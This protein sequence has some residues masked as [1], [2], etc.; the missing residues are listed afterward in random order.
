MRVEAAERRAEIVPT[1][2]PTPLIER[3]RPQQ[4]GAALP[5]EFHAPAVPP[6]S[7]APP[8]APIVKPTDSPEIVRETLEEVYA[9]IQSQGGGWFKFETASTVSKPPL[10]KTVTDLAGIAEKTFDAGLS[11]SV[12]QESKT[13]ERPDSKK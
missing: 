7:L 5:V 8:A 11:S 6:A 4:E 10:E 2:T 3:E 9:S 1:P 13:E 12:L